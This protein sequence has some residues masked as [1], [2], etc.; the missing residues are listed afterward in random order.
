MALTGMDCSA[1]DEQALAPWPV[2]LFP[3]RV[4]VCWLGN[5]AI[6]AAISNEELE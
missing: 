6:R 3:C 2:L 4:Q 5:L 1:W